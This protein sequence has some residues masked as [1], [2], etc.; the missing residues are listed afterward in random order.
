MPGS[1]EDID[2]ILRSVGAEKGSV[3]YPLTVEN[4]AYVRSECLSPSLQK[5]THMERIR[6]I[7]NRCHVFHLNKY[8]KERGVVFINASNRIK[9]EYLKIRLP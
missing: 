2:E 5:V 7:Q 3:K 1:Q 9:T 8:K 4:Y 6:A